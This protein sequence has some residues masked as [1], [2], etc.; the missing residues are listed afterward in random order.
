MDDHDDDGFGDVGGDEY[1]FNSDDLIAE[2]SKVARQLD[3]K[4]LK[5]CMWN[6]LVEEPPQ[7]AEHHTFSK[8]VSDVPKV[9][10][11]E[12]VSNVSVPYCFICLLHLANEKNLTI[13]DQRDNEVNDLSEL[14]IKL[15]D[16]A[17]A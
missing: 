14:T 2:P 17:V 13:T 4:R 15:S 10:P 12:M 7:S 1:G 9:I 6:Q 3:V 8:V 16:M 11:A 5:E